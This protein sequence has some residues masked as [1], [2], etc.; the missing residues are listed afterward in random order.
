MCEKEKSSRMKKNETGYTRVQSILSASIPVPNIPA[1][2]IKHFLIL[3]AKMSRSR[4]RFSGK[5]PR[6][7]YVTEAGANA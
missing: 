5:R 3:N 1:S 6:D 7:I 4:G 2:F